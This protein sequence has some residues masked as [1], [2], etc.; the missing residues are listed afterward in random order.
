LSFV[1]SS[2]SSFAGHLHRSFVIVIV[3][4]PGARHLPLSGSY[5][6]YKRDIIKNPTEYND[7]DMAREVPEQARD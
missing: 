7:Y 3:I 4:V 1:P 6:G 2:S 5:F